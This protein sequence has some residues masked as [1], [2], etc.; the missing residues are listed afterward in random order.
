MHCSRLEPSIKS[1][2]RGTRLNENDENTE[3][4]PD[5]DEK[6]HVGTHD[7]HHLSKITPTQSISRSV[8]RPFP[9][10]RVSHQ[11]RG[12][13]SSGGTGKLVPYDRVGVGKGKRRGRLHHRGRELDQTT[14]D[15]G[16]G[17]YG[18]KT[19]GGGCCI[20]GQSGSSCPSGQGYTKVNQDG[21]W[22]SSPITVDCCKGPVF[23][24]CIRTCSCQSQ[25]IGCQWCTW[26]CHYRARGYSLGD[27][28]SKCVS[29]SF[30]CPCHCFNDQ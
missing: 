14:C 1:N 25:S 15:A 12:K 26:G 13:D 6:E 18:T 27:C 28:Q 21:G 23:D 3:D 24:A 5:H 8:S 17:D 7:H 4:A 29:L 30:T 10:P 2:G 11:S 22:F 19:G 16:S 20:I 9:I